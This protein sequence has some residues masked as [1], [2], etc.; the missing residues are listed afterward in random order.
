MQHSVQQLRAVRHMCRLPNC[1]Q[2]LAPH[3]CSAPDQDPA[4][5]PDEEAA[6]PNRSCRLGGIQGSKLQ[7]LAVGL[8]VLEAQQH[9]PQNKQ[10]RC[11][12]PGHAAAALLLLLLLLCLLSHCASILVAAGLAT[13]VAAFTLGWVGRLLPRQQP[14]GRRRSAFGLVQPCSR[15]AHPQRQ[16]AEQRNEQEGHCPIGEQ[17]V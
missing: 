8:G 2:Q 15:F 13:T 6:G 12:A 3:P 7:A 16:V 5:L 4:C 17:L 1:M 9:R 11:L 10:L 14:P